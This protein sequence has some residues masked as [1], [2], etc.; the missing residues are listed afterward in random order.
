MKFV[1]DTS[2]IILLSKVD[3]LVQAD[4]LCSEIAIPKSVLIELGQKSNDER[5]TKFVSKVRTLE[6]GDTASA[7]IEWNLGAGESAVLSYALSH[8]DCVCVV[9][10]LAARN[11]ALTYGLRVI[12]TAGIMVALKERG[13]ITAVRPKL[14]DLVSHGMYISQKLRTEILQMTGEL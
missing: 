7:V 10:D 8:P 3:L 13:L 2:P 12:G 5:L 1:F 9:D 11:F 14:D 6:I 4:S